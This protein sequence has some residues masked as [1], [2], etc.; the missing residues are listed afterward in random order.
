MNK[1]TLQRTRKIDEFVDEYIVI[2]D[3][4]IREYCNE[5]GLN[6]D[7]VDLEELAADYFDELWSLGEEWEGVKTFHSEGD[8]DYSNQHIHFGETWEEN[9]IAYRLDTG[10]KIK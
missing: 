3:L 2:D 8:E 10:T 1:Y 6:F 4:K 5:I 7:T 9:G